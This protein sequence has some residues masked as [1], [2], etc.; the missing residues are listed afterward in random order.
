MKNTTK[1]PKVLFLTRLFYPHIGGVETHVGKISHLLVNMGFEITIITEHYDENL[2]THEALDGINIYRIPI[3]NS[4]KNKKFEIWKWM[5]THREMIKNHDVIHI[6]DVFFWIL[7]LF[8]ILDRKKIFTTFHGYESYPVSIS[9]KIQKKIAAKFSKGNI[10]VGEFIKKWFGITSNAVI[11]GGVDLPSITANEAKRAHKI[12]N[13]LYIGRL[14]CDMASLEYEKTLK[15]LKKNGVS[16]NLVVCGEGEFR[17]K[18]EKIGNVVGFVTDL[19]K[20]IE[21][22]DIV[23]SSSYLAMLQVM[24]Q[25]KPI[26]AIYDNPLKEDYLKKSPFEKYI[27]VNSSGEALY[28]QIKNNKMYELPIEDGYIWAKSQTWVKVAENYKSLWKI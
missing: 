19:D 1:R 25:K 27:S 20:Y 15:K 11:Y 14:S 13:I 8:F 21:K 5:I 2:K 7:P 9:S 28:R 22:T 16:F 26:F 23:F 18:Y 17:N 24:M 6:H 3:K 10:V 12:L 4:D